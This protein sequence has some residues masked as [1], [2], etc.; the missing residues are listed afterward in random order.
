MFVIPFDVDA[1]CDASSSLNIFGV[2]ED[3]AA[4][5]CL[6]RLKFRL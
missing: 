5:L 1:T 2:V 4:C 3:V 6:V